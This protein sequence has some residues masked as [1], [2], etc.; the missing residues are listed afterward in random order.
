MGGDEISIVRKAKEISEA[1]SADK[2]LSIAVLGPGLDAPDNPGSLKRK[3]I[4]DELEKDG[5]RPFF[6]EHRVSTGPT[7]DSLLDQERRILVDSGVDLVI[8]LHTSESVGTIAELAAFVGIPEIKSKTAILFPVEYYTPDQALVANTVREYLIRTVYPDEH[9]KSCQVVA[10][11][12]KWAYDRA[13][14]R[15]P[16]VMPFSF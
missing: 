4:H 7:Q 1:E 14:G 5:H 6:P 13:R 10:E 8:I 15:W 9:L 16:V 12:R 11:C 2:S 3:Q